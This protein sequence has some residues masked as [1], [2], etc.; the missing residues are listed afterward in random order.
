MVSIAS[1]LCSSIKQAVRLLNDGPDR[2]SV[3]AFDVTMEE[4]LFRVVFWKVGTFVSLEWRYIQESLS[5]EKI[6]CTH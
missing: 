6:K 5:K 1:F 4:I 2:Q 3:T